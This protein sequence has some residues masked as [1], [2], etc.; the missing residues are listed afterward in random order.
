LALLAASVLTV[1]LSTVTWTFCS[2][3]SM[4]SAMSTCFDAPAVTII[5][6]VVLTAN[7][8]AVVFRLYVLGGSPRRT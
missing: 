5:A 3:T 2:A 8:A 4:V 6:G 7:P 1:G